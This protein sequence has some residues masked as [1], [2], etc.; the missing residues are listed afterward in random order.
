M[1]HSKCRKKI[2]W[3]QIC[4]KN[5]H[6]TFIYKIY[7]NF[8]FTHQALCPHCNLGAAKKKPE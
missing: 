1:W 7:A 3:K 2:V 4:G 6:K 8:Y 5:P